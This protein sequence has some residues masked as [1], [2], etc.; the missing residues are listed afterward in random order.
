MADAV[1]AS[2][3]PSLRRAPLRA[4][5]WPDGRGIRSA[6]W[7]SS[8]T[9]SW[10]IDLSS[11]LQ[12]GDIFHPLQDPTNTSDSLIDASVAWMGPDAAGNW[13]WGVMIVAIFFLNIVG[14]ELLWRGVLWPRQELVHGERTWL[15]HGF[16]WYLFHLPFYPWFVISGLPQAFILS[17]LFPE[18]Q[19]HVAGAHHAHH[20][21]FGLLRH[22]AADSPGRHRLAPTSLGRG[23]RQRQFQRDCGWLMP[24][25]GIRTRSLQPL[26]TVRRCPF[27]LHLL[28]LG[29][30]DSMSTRPCSA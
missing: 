5:D 3:I 14:E 19:E 23:H 16:M 2:R 21:Q 10:I 6:P 1:E 13:L 17:Y 24:L 8:P 15:V 9:Q 27:S 4:H 25:S 12:P 26:S 29:G 28:S 30:G 7:C 11:W 20:L 22:L 18:D